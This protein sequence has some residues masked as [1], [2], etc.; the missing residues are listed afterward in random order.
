MKIDPAA[1]KTEVTP[2]ADGKG[3]NQGTGKPDD[4]S[5]P[6]VQSHETLHFGGL[7]DQYDP[8]TDKPNPGEEGSLMGDPR[9]PDSQF[10]QEEVDQMGRQACDSIQACGDKNPEVKNDNP[11]KD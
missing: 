10:T 6:T 8:A 9:N 1:Q 3:A 4:V 5:E 2:R 11:V 7:G